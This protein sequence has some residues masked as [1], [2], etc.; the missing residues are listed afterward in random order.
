MTFGESGFWQTKIRY[1]RGV[2]SEK[3][4]LED[5]A[6]AESKMGAGCDARSVEFFGSSTNEQVGI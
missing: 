2:P 1:A 5:E 4:S 3:I 6:A